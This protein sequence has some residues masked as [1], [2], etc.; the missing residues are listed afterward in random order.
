MAELWKPKSKEVLQDWIDALVDS[1][2]ELTSWEMNF[3]DSIQTSLH[4]YGSLTQPQETTLERI[5]A[6]KTK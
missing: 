1:S 2:D 3:V 5:Y 4:K 6:E